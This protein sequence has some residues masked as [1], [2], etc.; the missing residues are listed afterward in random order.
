MDNAEICLN[1]SLSPENP[2]W[3]YRCGVFFDVVN[4]TDRTLFLTGLTAGSHG[5]DQEATLYV[6]TEG[7]SSGHETIE[8]DWKIL[9]SG[10][11]TQRSSTP[12]KLHVLHKLE[13]HATQGLL[14]VSKNYAIYHTTSPK[15]VEDDNIRLCAG[16]RST[17]H[18]GDM[19]PFDASAHSRSERA[20]HAGSVSYMFGTS[21]TILCDA[22]APDG[23]GVTSVT[24]C[25]VSG[26]ELAVL[27]T[28]S[29]ETVDSLRTMI[30]NVLSSQLSDTSS[31]VVELIGPTGAVL[32]GTDTVLNALCGGASS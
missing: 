23:E 1:C 8:S 7:A 10:T 26:E 25:N 13:P 18:R 5:G 21:Y 6:C 15:P 16:V 20:T 12:V 3:A 11:L 9:W 22:T 28:N 29:T 2:S 17:E 30:A 19:N 24:C 27:S 32:E 14:L 31:L 4:K